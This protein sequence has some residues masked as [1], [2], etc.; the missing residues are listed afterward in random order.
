MAV[1]E[2]G[3]A[4]EMGAALSRRKEKTLVFNR[5]RAQ[6][7]FPMRL[8]CGLGKSGGEGDGFSALREHLAKQ[9]GKAQVVANRQSQPSNR[10]VDDDHFVPRSK[11][12]GFLV[13]FAMGHADIEQVNF[14]VAALE[15]AA[16]IKD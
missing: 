11:M 5:T 4:W 12:R 8:T 10:A 13:G 9:F 16:L 15:D 2:G 3:A 7:Y 14:V 6:Q 1:T